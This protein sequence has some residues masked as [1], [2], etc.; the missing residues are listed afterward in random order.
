MNNGARPHFHNKLS[1]RGAKKIPSLRS[2]Q[3][4]QSLKKRKRDEQRE[5]MNTPFKEHEVE[6]YER[7]RY[8]GI[9]QRLVHRREEKLLRKI[10]RKIGDG[11][12]LVLDVPCGYG[13]FSD[14]LLDKDFCLVSSDISFPMVKRAREKSGHP[15]SRFLSGVVADAKQGL[16]FKKGA[17]SLLLSMRFFH[18]VHEK[19]EREFILK[20]F[21]QATSDWVILSYYQKNL[22]H[23]LQ[24]RLRRKIK[25]SRTR[26]KMIP[27][28]E[29]YKDVEGAGLRVV[30]ISPLFRGIHAHHI[31]LLKKMG[32]D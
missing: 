8:R 27:R 11:P 22:L 32:T 25:R 17:F 13:R 29:F 19:E 7:K 15:H 28:K 1:L 5:V 31:A 2:E 10:L 18:H 3:A 16:P 26:I 21:Y 4:L 24:R 6:E 20:E 9:D 23:N 30:K 14:L 12:L